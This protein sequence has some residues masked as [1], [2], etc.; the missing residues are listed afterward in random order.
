MRKVSW[1]IGMVL[2]C[3]LSSSSLRAQWGEIK[4]EQI[5]DAFLRNDAPDA[6]ESANASL[7]IHATD[8]AE[9]G[10]ALLILQSQD[11]EVFSAYANGGVS[12]SGSLAVEGNAEFGMPSETSSDAEDLRAGW[13]LN[14]SSGTLE[15]FEGTAFYDMTAYNAPTYG[16]AGVFGNALHFESDASQYAEVSSALG[17]TGWPV[18]MTGWFKTSTV[19]AQTIFAFADASVGNVAYGL[20]VRSLGHAMGMRR[21]TT[22]TYALGNSFVCDGEWH[23]A[24]LVIAGDADSKLYVDGVLEAIDTTSVSWNGAID[25]S[26]IGRYG[27]SSPSGYF[28]GTLDEVVIYDAALSAGAIKDL[29]ARGNKTRIREGRLSAVIVD[30]SNVAAASV[31][32]RDD[33]T[34]KFGSDFTRP[35]PVMEDSQEYPHPAIYHG[36]CSDGSITFTS[37]SFRT[38]FASGC[39]PVVTLTPLALLPEDET[40]YYAYFWSVD[41]RSNTGFSYWIRRLGFLKSTYELETT[42]DVTGSF[43]VHWQ[44]M[45]WVD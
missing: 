1:R 9:P 6:M 17:I 40:Y 30:A 45:G 39:L 44:A 28:D 4:K 29:Y 27:D 13:H 18:T 42:G 20:E 38:P 22:A 11:S 3:L 19:A 26:S 32:A 34:Q 37:D 16:T 36:V 31:I 5:E 43:A 10:Q 25:T 24:A 7:R 15:N 33:I 12:F 14:E 35:V 2:L 21:N 41:T 8:P 23:H